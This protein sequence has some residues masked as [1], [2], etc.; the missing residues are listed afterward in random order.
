MPAHR[1]CVFPLV[2][3]LLF[4]WLGIASAQDGHSRLH[5]IPNQEPESQVFKA[6]IGDLFVFLDAVIAASQKPSCEEMG[7]AVQSI[8]A[9]VKMRAA[10]TIANINDLYIS[11]ETIL[12]VEAR[13]SQIAK[14]AVS[15][16][17]LLFAHKNVA[18]VALSLE[19]HQKESV[20]D[21]NPGN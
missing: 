20:K 14:A 16:P 17:P 13:S 19:K 1:I 11:D 5:N 18:T 8:S 10:R 21:N 15:C 3:S 6:D 2:F 4:V 12:E 9:D 7:I